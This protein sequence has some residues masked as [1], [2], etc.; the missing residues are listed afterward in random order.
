MLKMAKLALMRM[1][2]LWTMTMLLALMTEAMIQAPMTLMTEMMV[3]GLM[4]E[5]MLLGLMT[6]QSRESSQHEIPARQA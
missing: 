2:T 6:E 4:T 5:M 3:L 1:P